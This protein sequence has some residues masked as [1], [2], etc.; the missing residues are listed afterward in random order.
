MNE[1]HSIETLTAAIYDVVRNDLLCAGDEF[2]CDSNLID[3]GLDSRSVAQLLLEIEERTG[4]WLPEALLTTNN[5]ASCR[6]LAAC[7]HRAL[8]DADQK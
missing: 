6:T 5:L 8:S 2:D 4:L 3:W 7:V 1:K